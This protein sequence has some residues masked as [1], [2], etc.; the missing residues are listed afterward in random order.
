MA[1]FIFLVVCFLMCL[2]VYYI[3]RYL[4]YGKDMEEWDKL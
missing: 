4:A 1:L 2:G 3:G